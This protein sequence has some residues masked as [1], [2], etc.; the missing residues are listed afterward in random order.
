LREGLRGIPACV[1]LCWAMR[2]W[3]REDLAVRAEGKDFIGGD[4][5]YI[6]GWMNKMGK[7]F[8]LGEIYCR[9]NTYS[10][11]TDTYDE[12]HSSDVTFEG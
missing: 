7:G 11:I 12:M 10:M 2:R 4:R 1:E 9:N 8:G 3:S 5:D 6:S